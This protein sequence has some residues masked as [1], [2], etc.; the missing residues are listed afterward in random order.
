MQTV[1]VL[2][3]LHNSGCSEHKANDEDDEDFCKIANIQQQ[4]AMVTKR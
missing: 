2:E 1:N 3:K 4:E